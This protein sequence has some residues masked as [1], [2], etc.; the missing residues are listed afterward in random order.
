MRSLLLILGCLAV[1]STG[2]AQ[3]PDW[4]KIPSRTA[5]PVRQY[6]AMVF[7]SARHRTVLFG[8]G[9]VG[10]FLADTWEW[11]GSNWTEFKPANSPAAR[12]GHAMAYDPVRRRTVLF[13][14]SGGTSTLADTWEWDGGNWI[15]VR[16]TTSPPGRQLHAMAH[17]TARQ[18]MVLFGGTSLVGP[19]ET[20]E[21]SGTNWT[22]MTP[23]A[24]PLFRQCPVM[25]YDTVRQR[26]VLHGGIYVGGY[27]SDTWEYGLATPTLTANTPRIAIATGGTQRL[28]LNA[29]TGL[30]NKPYWMLGSA[31]CT[32]PRVVW[33]GIHIPLCPDVYTDILIGVGNSRATT[34][35]KG[36]L[37]ATGTA[38]ALLNVPANLPIPSGFRLVHAYVVYDGTSGRLFTS[39]N[40]VLVEFQ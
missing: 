34:S 31:T 7:D 22:R 36:R 6:S 12:W 13:G 37:S 32:M 33:T 16:P 19:A 28:T 24:S 5:P 15:R 14:G 10:G 26:V 30:G 1:A 11:D 25:A 27:S 23:S 29:G 17:D 9:V 40:P 39:S 2:P 20:W 8:G 3:A 21:W 18:R 35:F 4:K 38:T